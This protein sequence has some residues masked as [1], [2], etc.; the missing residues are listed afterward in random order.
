M[1]KRFFNICVVFCFFPFQLQA[2]NDIEYNWYKEYII[3]L[4]QEG[5]IDGFEDGSFHPEDTTTRA[6]I[7][8]IIMNSAAIEL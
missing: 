2:F 7:L 6:E 4:E 1:L 5:V 3:A 8:K